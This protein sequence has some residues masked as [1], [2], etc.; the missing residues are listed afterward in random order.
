[1]NG[2][3]A[4][5]V[6]QSILLAVG[7]L[8]I[9]ESL[10]GIRS[11]PDSVSRLAFHAP[12]PTTSLGVMDAALRAEILGAIPKDA[13]CELRKRV[14]AGNDFLAVHKIHGLVHAL[15]LYGKDAPQGPTDMDGLAMLRVLTDHGAFERFTKGTRPLYLRSPY[16]INVRVGDALDAAPHVDKILA[17]F[18]ET[19]ITVETAIQLEDG[20]EATVADLLR[21]AVARFQIDQGE[22]EWTSVALASYLPRQQCWVNRFGEKFAFDDVVEALTRR[23]FGDG[24]CYG[25]HALYALAYI[26]RHD[27]EQTILS[28]QSCSAA[29]SYLRAASARLEHNQYKT[30]HWGPDW[31][32]LTGEMRNEILPP[33]LKLKNFLRATGHHLEWIAIAPLDCR[34]KQKCILRAARV[35]AFDILLADRAE[36]IDSYAPA[37]HAARALL[38]LTGEW[39]MPPHPVTF[40]SQ[41]DFNSAEEVRR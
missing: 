39:P 11:G 9:C 20:G 38:L 4:I 2:R 37:T 17:V 19:G 25:A 35:T 13:I 32:N 24:S 5:M 7:A 15:R 36:L 30:G 1:M 33:G 29:R 34:P 22:L 28:P 14:R 12:I 10:F 21:D 27:A 40:A 16:G 23:D 3:K 8:L 18:G 26:L 6:V 41:R 31:P